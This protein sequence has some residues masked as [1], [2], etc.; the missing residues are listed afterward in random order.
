MLKRIDLATRSVDVV[1]HDNREIVY[2]GMDQSQLLWTSGDD[3]AIHLTRMGTTS[4]PIYSNGTPV[5]LA[6]AGERVFWAGVDIS[7]QLGALQSMSTNGTGAREVARFSGGFH[8]MAGNSTYLYY[9]EGSPGRIHR[10]TLTSG[11]D[12]VVDEHAFG[13]S[14]FAIDETHAYWTEP[15]DGDGS[16][17]LVRRVAHDSSTAE[18]LAVSVALPLAIAVSRGRV[19]VASAGSS[20]EAFADGKSLRLTITD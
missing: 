7:G 5:A 10:R 18:T 16:S 8:T 6:V 1:V 9:G 2:V 4:I 19:F 20:K 14:D 17:G 3:N 15:G 11:R 13:V 12:E